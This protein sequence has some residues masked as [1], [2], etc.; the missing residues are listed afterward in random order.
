MKTKLELLAATVLVLALASSAFGQVPGMMNYQGRILVGNANFNG[1]G[2]F[3]FALV[4]GNGGIS[5]WS[6]DG[7]SVAG[8]NRR[9]RCRSMGQGTLFRAAGRRRCRT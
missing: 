9:P 7:T 2:Q 3:K 1:N 6:N 5:F 4:D 8:V